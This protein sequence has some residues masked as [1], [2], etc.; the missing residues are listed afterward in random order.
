M[1]DNKLKGIIVRVTPL[2]QNCSII[3]CSAT[4]NAAIVDPGGDIEELLKVIKSQ[5]LEVKNIF[6]THAHIDHAG[7]AAE[8]SEKLDAPIIG[9][10]KEDLFLIDQLEESGQQ[11]GIPGARAFEPSRWLEDGDKVELGELHLD[12]YHC[13]GHTPGH[14]I[15][16]HPESQL[17]LVGDVIFSGSIGRTD[18]PRGDFESLIK[19]ITSKLWPLGNETQFIPGHGEPSTFGKER[20]SNPYVSDLIMSSKN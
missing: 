6:I 12:V 19:S 13:P 4:N 15:F 18:F 20:A 9:P 17:A 7:A 8:I 14:V 16:H 10:H 1:S 2:Q 11:Y 5:N 3:W